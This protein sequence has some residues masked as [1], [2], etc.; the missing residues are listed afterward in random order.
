MATF[1]TVED[2]ETLW[3]SLKFDERKRAEALLSIVSDSLREEAKKVS[4][5]LDKMVDESPS[6]SSVVKSVTVDVVA[7]TLMTST[8]QEPMTQM[9]ESAMGYSFSGSYLVPGG[10]LFIKDS[11]LKRL[12][13]KKQRYGVIELYGTN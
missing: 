11:E 1:A 3:R 7:R 13:L 8:D 12:G 6:Y 2:L 5:D 9:A 4:K 10:G